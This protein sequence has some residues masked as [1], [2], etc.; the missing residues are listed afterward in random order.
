MTQEEAQNT[1][2][3]LDAEPYISLMTFKRDGSGVETPVW[4][5]RVDDAFYVFTESKA[6]KVKRLRRDPHARIAACG[7]VGAVHGE[8]HEAQASILDTDRS[9]D[10]EKERRAYEALDKKYGWQMR[11]A[12][13]FSKL[14]G[15]F[16]A[17]AMLEIRLE[18]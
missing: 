11:A 18:E 3:A 7:V 6:Y 15:R 10:K 4:H 9:E 8:W 17:R 13:L 16:N 12:N 14:A 5:A 2:A 1:L